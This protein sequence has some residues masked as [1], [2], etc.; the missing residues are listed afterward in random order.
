VVLTLVL[1]P[2]VGPLC[3]GLK[4]LKNESTLVYPF[5]SSFL[6]FTFDF[7][8]LL[9]EKQNHIVFTLQYQHGIR[10]ETVFKV[11]RFIVFCKPQDVL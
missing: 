4:T 5:L 6:L 10:R 1:L 7:I 2:M 9:P 8:L 11:L 3:Q